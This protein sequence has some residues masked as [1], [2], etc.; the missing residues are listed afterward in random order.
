MARAKELITQAKRVTSPA[1]PS[2]SNCAYLGYR[3]QPDRLGRNE[4]IDTAG[5]QYAEIG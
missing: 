5:N 4:S 3:L 2:Q 1:R